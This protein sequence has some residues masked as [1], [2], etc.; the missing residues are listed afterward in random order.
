M[1]EKNWWG[2]ERHPSDGLV[3]WSEP[4]N[5]KAFEKRIRQLRSDWDLIHSTPELAAAFK[6]LAEATRDKAASDQA[7]ADAGEDL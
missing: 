1:A 3:H 2:M 5:T 4:D 7:D 6:R